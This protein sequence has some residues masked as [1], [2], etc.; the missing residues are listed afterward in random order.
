MTVQ[1][2]EIHCPR[3]GD[4]MEYKKTFTSKQTPGQY[5]R[6]YHCDK[7]DLSVPTLDPDTSPFRKETKDEQA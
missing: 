1:K 7:C 5:T 2:L 3:C 6:E 4:I